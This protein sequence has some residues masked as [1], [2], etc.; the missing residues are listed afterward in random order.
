MAAGLEEHVVLLRSAQ[1][2]ALRAN[3]VDSTAKVPVRSMENDMTG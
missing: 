1:V 2:D 3:T